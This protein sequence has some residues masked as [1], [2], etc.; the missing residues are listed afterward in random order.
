MNRKDFIRNISLVG[1][2]I[3]LAPTRLFA[4]NKASKHY[5]LPKPTVHIPH[6]NFHATAIEKLEIPELELACTVQRFMRNG[7]SEN[8]DDL[9]VFSFTSENE[10]LHIC[11][12]RSGDR[13]ID[14]SISRFNIRV[15]DFDSTH[16]S[17]QQR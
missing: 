12:T 16:F 10:Q 7:I 2:G 13:F 11:I 8:A 14:G 1:A 9:T 5:L 6:G 3:S 15:N 17:F 4:S